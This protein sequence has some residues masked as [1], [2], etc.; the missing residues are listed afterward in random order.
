VEDTDQCLPH[1]LLFC[2]LL[3][4]RSVRRVSFLLWLSSP[5][6]T[7]EGK[8]LQRV[9][10][11]A[12]CSWTQRCGLATKQCFFVS[13]NKNSCCY[14]LTSLYLRCLVYVGAFNSCKI[15]L[16]GPSKSP[17]ITDRDDWSLGEIQ[18]LHYLY[19]EWQ[20]LTCT[21]VSRLQAQMVQSH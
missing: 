18:H 11:W 9:G 7:L 5:V 12:G 1:P 20:G 14:F 8:H 17:Q 21:P 15:S 13:M 19:S 2:N 3:P 10:N 16:Y 4:Y 6:S